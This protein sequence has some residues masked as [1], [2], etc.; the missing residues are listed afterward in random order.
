MYDDD[1][2]LYAAAVSQ[3]ELFLNLSLEL[4]ALS[5]WLK[6]NK[7]TLNVNETRLVIFGSGHKLE[8]PPKLALNIDGKQIEQI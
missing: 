6:A 3:F 8:Q 5:E 2:A 1:T 7:H 4:A